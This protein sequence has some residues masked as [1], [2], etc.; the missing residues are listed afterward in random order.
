M[1]ALVVVVIYE[2]QS[3]IA[4]Q[5]LPV[6]CGEMTK[7]WWQREVTSKR[8]TQVLA[9]AE[10]SH[11]TKLGVLTRGYTFS[12]Q[13]YH[14]LNTSQQSCPSAV[15]LSSYRA[16][17]LKVEGTRK[18]GLIGGF[19]RRRTREFS[20]ESGALFYPRKKLNLGLADIQFSVVLG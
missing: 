10:L 20:R 7:Y 14:L 13:V 1:S 16:R 4:R 5:P 2:D 18:T 19:S 12:A 17:C 6:R 11:S 9:V 3:T 8:L 15:S